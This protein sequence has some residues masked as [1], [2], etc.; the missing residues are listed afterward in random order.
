ML[1]LNFEFNLQAARTRPAACSVLS[2]GKTYKIS[3]K[4]TSKPLRVSLKHG[5]FSMGCLPWLPYSG[6]SRLTV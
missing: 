3:S 2:P 6:G 5:T 1:F 4:S